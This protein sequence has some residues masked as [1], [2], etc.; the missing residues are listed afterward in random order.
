MSW[1]EVTYKLLDGV[2]ALVALILFFW[3]FF[4]DSTLPEILAA[5][6]KRK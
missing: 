1:A 3:F 2:G 6:R 4:G 5:W